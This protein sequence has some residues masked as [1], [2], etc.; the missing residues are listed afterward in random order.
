MHCADKTQAFC[1]NPHQLKGQTWR[2]LQVQRLKSSAALELRPECVCRLV[3]PQRRQ[4]LKHAEAACIAW[5]TLTSRQTQALQCRQLTEGLRRNHW[6]IQRFQRGWQWLQRASRKKMAPTA[7]Q[8]GTVLPHQHM[9]T[10]RLPSSRVCLKCVQFQPPNVSKQW[11]VSVIA[12]DSIPLGHR[13][14]GAA[15]LG[16]RSRTA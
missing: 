12:K 5:L 3:Q 9:H 14:R 13:D 2:T 7:R 4:P 10:D 15:G 16:S 6:H 11:Q 8:H 1:D